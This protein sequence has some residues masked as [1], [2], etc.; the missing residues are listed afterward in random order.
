LRPRLI[1]AS[2]SS[3]ASD[4]EAKD[5]QLTTGSS[6]RHIAAAEPERSSAEALIADSIQAEGDHYE[7]PRQAAHRVRTAPCDAVD[8]RCR[9]RRRV[10]RDETPLFHSTQTLKKSGC[11]EKNIDKK[12]QMSSVSSS[13]R[14]S[15][16]SAEGLLLSENGLFIAK[17]EF[18]V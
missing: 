13:N 14:M 3:R 4:R 16:Q 12:A 6:G 18:L 1:V 11:Y 9:R 17:M 7:Q 8:Q 10:L 15:N 2:T 5:G